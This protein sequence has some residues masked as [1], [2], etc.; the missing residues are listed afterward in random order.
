MT[1][2]NTRPAVD[3]R[4]GNKP[5]EPNLSGNVAGSVLVEAGGVLAEFWPNQHEHFTCLS[6][7]TQLYDAWRARVGRVES[8]VDAAMK[9]LLMSVARTLTAGTSD[10][11]VFARISAL[12]GLAFQMANPAA[13]SPEKAAQ[14]AADTMTEQLVGAMGASKYTTA[15]LDAD[16]KSMAA[17]LAPKL[18][19]EMMNLPATTKA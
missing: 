7:F 15:S 1:T 3:L 19:E 5:S 18:G 9:Q 4:A 13:G 16:L 2:Q 12:S 11:A 6:E 14:A 10:R 8:P 17:M